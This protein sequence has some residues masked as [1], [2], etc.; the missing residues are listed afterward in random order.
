MLGFVPYPN[1]PGYQDASRF[2]W[3]THGFISIGS[4]QLYLWRAVGLDG[5]VLDIVVQNRKDK[6]ATVR[7]FK[8]LMKGQ[9]RDLP[10]KS[11]RTNSPATVR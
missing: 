9:S 3:L 2:T 6:R 1:L 7:F 5:D 11:S 10:E 4:K 8:Q